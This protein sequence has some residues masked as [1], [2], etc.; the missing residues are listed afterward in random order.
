MNLKYV[1]LI[2]GAFAVGLGHQYGF[3]AFFYAGIVACV[4]GFFKALFEAAD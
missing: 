4:C 2:G 1:L 3:S